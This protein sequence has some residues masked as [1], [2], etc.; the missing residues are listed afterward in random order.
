LDWLYS[1]SEKPF[2]TVQ[3]KGT[4]TIRQCEVDATMAAG[5]PLAYSLCPPSSPKAETREKPFPTNIS[6]HG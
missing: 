2:I 6:Q 4:V 3:Q 1:A 5:E